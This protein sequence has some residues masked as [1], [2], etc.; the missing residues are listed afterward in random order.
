MS[1]VAI[2]VLARKAKGRLGGLEPGDVGT[3]RM[4]GL[5]TGSRI[6]G[7]LSEAVH[8]LGL[9]AAGLAIPDTT[10]SAVAEPGCPG[11]AR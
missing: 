5:F 7:H 10:H 4:F 11:H 8:F 6:E 3:V 2:F 1:H 9:D